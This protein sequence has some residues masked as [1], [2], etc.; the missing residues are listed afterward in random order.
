MNEPTKPEVDAEDW[1]KAT[2]VEL[3]KVADYFL[4]LRQNTMEVVSAAT[5]VN[6]DAARLEEENTE[7]QA[8]VKR[9]EDELND[10][11]LV[12]QKLQDERDKAISLADRLEKAADAYVAVPCGCV[13]DGPCDHVEV[14]TNWIKAKEIK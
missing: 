14:Y 4:A 13:C 6:I 7:L 8:R 5:Q 9:L 12:L 3:C 10:N 11:G 1:L 2:S